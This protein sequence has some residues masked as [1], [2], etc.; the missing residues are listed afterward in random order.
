MHVYQ[1]VDLQLSKKYGS[2]IAKYMNHIFENNKQYTDSKDPVLIK[3]G[4]IFNNVITS[5]GKCTRFIVPRFIQI[6]Q[7]ED[8]FKPVENVARENLFGPAN[9]YDKTN[10]HMNN[11]LNNFREG[12]VETIENKEFKDAIIYLQTPWDIESDLI[13][14][15]YRMVI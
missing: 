15:L 2:Y 14:D 7:D 1:K 4:I 11:V 5:Y 8:L 3:E 9:H 13:I 6:N 10:E 12:F